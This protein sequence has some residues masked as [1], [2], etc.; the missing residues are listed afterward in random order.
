MS[1]TSVKLGDY[2]VSKIGRFTLR[3]L[4]SPKKFRLTN[5][6]A[7]IPKGKTIA[8]KVT[9]RTPEGR[10]VE[11]LIVDRISIPLRPDELEADKHNVDVLIRHPKVKIG[12][13][14]NEQWRALIDA[15]LK[16]AKPEFELTNIDQQNVEQMNEEADLVIVRAMLLNKKNPIGVEKLQWLCTVFGLG[17]KTNISDPE[18]HRATLVK[19]LDKFIQEPNTRVNGKSNLERFEDAMG[20]LKRTEAIYYVRELQSME[21]I[22]KFGGIYKVA[23][24]P[25][26]SSE[27]SVIDFYNDNP[28]IFAEHKNLVL[29]AMRSTV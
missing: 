28:E 23:E 11:S 13:I 26:G 6:P 12:G 22:T 5:V 7:Y 16:A 1:N 17:Y 9:F 29:Q 24:R 14:S 8:D 15:G 20:D 19:K 2:Q 27:D 4:K 3:V 18:R 25:V 10:Q 21:V